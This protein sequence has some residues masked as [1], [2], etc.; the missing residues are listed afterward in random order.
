MILHLNHT[1][2]DSAAASTSEVVSTFLSLLEDGQLSAAQFAR[3]QIYLDWVQYKQNF[4]EPITVIQSAQGETGSSS[5]VEVRIDSRQVATGSLREL[6]QKAINPAQPLSAGS[7]RIYLEDFRSFRSSMT[8]DFNQLYWQRLKDWETATGRGY[9]RALPGGESDGHQPQAISDSVT[10]FWKLLK[11]LDSQNKL[12]PELFVLEI[13][14]GLATRAGLWL[15]R[16]Y[17]LDQERGTSYYPRLRFLLGDY[18]LSTL[19]RSRPAV[20]RHLDLCSFI[21]LDALD[22]TKTLSFLRHK[23]LH[24]HSTNMYDNLPDEEIVWRDNRVYWV[25]VRAY[26]PASEAAR[27]GSACDVPIADIPKIV[28]RLI[29]VGADALPD[30]QKG[31]TFW[32]EIWKAIR[33]EEK[34]VDAVDLP[35]ASFPAGLSSAQMEDILSDAPGDLRLHL[36]SGALESFRNTLPLLHPRGYLQVQDIFVTDLHDY[37]MGFYGPGKLDGSIVNWVNGALLREVGARAGYDLHFAPFQ[38]RPGSKTSV[39]YTTQRE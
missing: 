21:A 14:V 17:A 10:E 3:L 30:H 28:R 34:L 26:V 31:M 7:D 27:I 15:D 39:L 33:M 22:P 12:P 24:V 38:Y 29:E 6:V 9:E 23:I 13:G 11:D 19:D 35:D 4:R 37:A 25:H 5:G 20:Q 8:W 16:F 18:S 36:S 1:R 2:R 32:M